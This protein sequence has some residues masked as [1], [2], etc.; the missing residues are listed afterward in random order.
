MIIA[1]TWLLHHSDFA[2]IRRFNSTLAWMNLALL[3]FIAMLPAPTS[4]LS[5]YGDDPTPWPSILYAAN[6][7]AI[8]LLL[9]GIW[10]YARHTNLMDPG[11]TAHVHRRIFTVRMAVPVVFLLSIPA[12]FALNAYTPLLWLLLLPASWL[13]RWMSTRSEQ[14]STAAKSSP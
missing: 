5:E 3:F 10:S 1:K 7:G 9:A 14:G 8:Y 6:I 2:L 12:A 13:S 4:V 11:M